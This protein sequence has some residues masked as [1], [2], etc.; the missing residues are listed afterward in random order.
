VYYAI[1]SIKTNIMTETEI[2]KPDQTTAQTAPTEV[3]ES[4]I[5]TAG[6]HDVVRGSRIGKL[7][8]MNILGHKPDQTVAADSNVVAI[9]LRTDAAALRPTTTV[10]SQ[11]STL[12]KLKDELGEPA[13]S[14][15][16]ATI[17]DR[18]LLQRRSGTAE[19]KPVLRTVETHEEPAAVEPEAPVGASLTG[20]HRGEQSQVQDLNYSQAGKHKAGVPIGQGGEFTGPAPAEVTPLPIPAEHANIERVVTHQ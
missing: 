20:S 5:A 15:P 14:E 2:T 19:A 17:A 3:A 9:P 4:Q 12:A 10:E 18:P 7:F 1:S 11:L 6:M 8:S 16:T 13:A